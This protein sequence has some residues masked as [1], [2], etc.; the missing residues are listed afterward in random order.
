MI[1]I[2]II[3]IIDNDQFHSVYQILYPCSCRRNCQNSTFLFLNCFILHRIQ[4]YFVNCSTV[5]YLCRFPENISKQFD[6]FKCFFVLTRTEWNY[7]SQQMSLILK[8]VPSL[9]AS[10]ICLLQACFRSSE[11]PNGFIGTL[12]TG[13]NY[14]QIRKT[15]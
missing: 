1:I 12:R 10:G 4:R 2:I 14:F 7:N 9:R 5:D 6:S 13:A 15:H 8:C 3:S 11:V